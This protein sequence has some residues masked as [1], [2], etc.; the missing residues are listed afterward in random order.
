MDRV[1][2]AAG[3]TDP[4]A[5]IG[6]CEPPASMRWRSTLG[7]RVARREPAALGPSVRDEDRAAEPA[8]TH[9]SC[10]WCRTP[11]QSHRR[12]APSASAATVPALDE[13]GEPIANRSPARAGRLE[14]PRIGGRGR[15]PPAYPHGRAPTL[16][17]SDC[18]AGRWATASHAALVWVSFRQ[19]AHSSEVTSFATPSRWTVSQDRSSHGG[20]P[21]WPAMSKSVRS[22]P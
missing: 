19:V 8:A 7:R 14:R 12:R 10:I 16:Q 15:R 17:E 13:P 4:P 3:D 2:R 20:T 6:A 11:T 21:R 1:P 22:F 5:D 18:R 9:W